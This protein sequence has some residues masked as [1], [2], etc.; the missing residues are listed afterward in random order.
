[1]KKGS[2]NKEKRERERRKSSIICKT[3]QEAHLYA[4]SDRY[5]IKRKWNILTFN[6]LHGV[7][8]TD[9]HFV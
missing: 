1:M 2:E 3:E 9:V 4:S 8:L 7:H 5:P 6:M